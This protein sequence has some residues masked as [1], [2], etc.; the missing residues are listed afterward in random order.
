MPQLGD[1]TVCSSAWAFVEPEVF[2]RD[3]SVG[4]STGDGQRGVEGRS[5]GLGLSLC[6]LV[7]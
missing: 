3:I 7:R 5:R 6:L 4:A 1:V 2:L